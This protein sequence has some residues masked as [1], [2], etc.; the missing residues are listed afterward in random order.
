M[1]DRSVGSIGKRIDYKSAGAAPVARVAARPDDAAVRRSLRGHVRIRSSRRRTRRGPSRSDLLPVN[2][3]SARRRVPA[4]SAGW[5]SRRRR[6]RRGRH[7]RRVLDRQRLRHRHRA[8]RA[9]RDGNRLGGEPR[10]DSAGRPAQV[11]RQ[12]HRRVLL[13]VQARQ[14]PHAD[15][16]RHR[17][18]HGRNL[19][20]ASRHGAGADDEDRQ[21]SAG[22]HSHGR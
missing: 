1:R 9:R 11:H 5:S 3:R 20:V 10:G 14:V 2:T 8:A 22:R 17:A 12:V 6:S 19:R 16:A 13:D 7:V 21:S 18:R 15:R 4:A